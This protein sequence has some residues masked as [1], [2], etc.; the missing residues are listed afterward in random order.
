[1]YE[2]GEINLFSGRT[3]MYTVLNAAMSNPLVMDRIVVGQT[4]LV[5]RLAAEIAKYGYNGSWRIGLAVGGI[6]MANSYALAKDIGQ[7]ADLPLWTKPTY[8][9]ARTASLAE[10][11]SSPESVV[12][13]LVSQLFRGLGSVEQFPWL[14]A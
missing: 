3:V 13:E 6:N 12:R 5:V 14:F 10:L 4:E 7:G 1:L 11:S 9:R 8:S 2:S